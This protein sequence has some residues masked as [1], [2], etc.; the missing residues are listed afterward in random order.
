MKNFFKYTTTMVLISQ[1]LFF[2]NVTHSE[3]IPTEYLQVKRQAKEFT[4]LIE[5]AN[6]IIPG[7]ISAYYEVGG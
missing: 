2:N 6:E 1:G 4:L 3:V 5:K 7:S